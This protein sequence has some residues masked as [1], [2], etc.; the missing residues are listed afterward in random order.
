MNENVKS[1]LGLGFIFGMAYLALA[2]D[3]SRATKKSNPYYPDPGKLDEQY[4]VGVVIEEEHKETI[5]KIIDDVRNNRVQDFKVYFGWIAK[6]HIKEYKDY[7]T[8][9]VKMEQQA[10]TE[11]K[12][13]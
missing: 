9:L 1:F 6:D 10:L 4:D 7:Y 8:R 5:Q 2:F 12:G 11:L 13:K 3:V